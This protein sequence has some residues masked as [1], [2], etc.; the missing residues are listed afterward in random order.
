MIVRAAV[1]REGLRA[2]GDGELLA[3]DAAERL[4]GGAGD[5]P[6]LRAV[7]VQGVAECVAHC[8]LHRAAQ[9]AAI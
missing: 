9:A 6:A 5:A 7:A 1:D 4:E 2:L 8:L 3:L